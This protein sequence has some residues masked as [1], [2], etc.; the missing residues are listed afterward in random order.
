[1]LS[2]NE[3]RLRSSP[4]FGDYGQEQQHTLRFISFQRK[5]ISILLG[6]PKVKDRK[7]SVWAWEFF[8]FPELVGP[9][10]FLNNN[11]YLDIMQSE[12]LTLA[13]NMWGF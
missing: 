11:V 10:H 9:N 3:S 7:E 12:Q 8:C 13:Q 2:F 5:K 1:M 6:L 4:P